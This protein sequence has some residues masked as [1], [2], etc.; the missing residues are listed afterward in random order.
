M[1]T[2]CRCQHRKNGCELYQWARS[3]GCSGAIWVVCPTGGRVGCAE[4]G[5]LHRRAFG[6]MW[7]GGVRPRIAI[8]HRTQAI[9]HVHSA[10]CIGVCRSLVVGARIC[11]YHLCPG[12]R[13]LTIPCPTEEYFDHELLMLIAGQINRLGCPGRGGGRV[14]SR[15]CILRKIGYRNVKYTGGQ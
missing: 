1:N 3:P 8:R 10:S 9:S 5:C 4:V 15:T 6:V 7:W 2:E 11:R 12:V 14:R 13:F